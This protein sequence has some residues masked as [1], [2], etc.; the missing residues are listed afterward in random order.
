MDLSTPPANMP[1]VEQRMES[2]RACR[3]IAFDPCQI[4][5]RVTGRTS[6]VGAVPALGLPIQIDNFVS[7]CVIK[8]NRILSHNYY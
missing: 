5:S 3:Y 8:T 1:A 4:F 2:T 7:G 6:K